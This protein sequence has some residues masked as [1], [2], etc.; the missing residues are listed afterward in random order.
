MPFEPVLG[1]SVPTRCLFRNDERHVG[2]PPGP[3]AATFSRSL[4]NEQASPDSHT[5]C[6]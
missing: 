2:P 4:D 1:Q 6:G 3:A 5:C